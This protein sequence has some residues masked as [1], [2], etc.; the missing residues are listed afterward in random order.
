[1]GKRDSRGQAAGKN[2]QKILSCVVAVFFSVLLIRLFSLQSIRY[3]E[4][5]RSAENNQLQAERVVAPRGYFE[6]RAGKIIADNVLRFEFVLPWKKEKE[7]RAAAATLANYL[8]IDSGQVMERFAGWQKKN[9]TTP[10]PIVLDADKLMISFVRENSDLFPNLRVKTRARRRYRQSEV[11]AHVLGYVGEVRD[12]DLLREGA[13]RYFPG[14]MTGKTGLELYCESDLRGI[15]GQRV[16]EVNASGN[17]LGEVT[18]LSVPPHLGKTIT[19]TLDSGL[20]AYLQK[21]MQGKGAG[22]A[23]VMDVNDGAILAAVSVPGYDPNEFTTGISQEK[24]DALFN[25]ET[26]PLF[27]RVHQARY[28]PASTLKIVAT[29]AILVNEIVDPNEILVYCTGSHAFGN[30]VYHCWQAGG[31]GA[32]NLYTAFVQSCDIYFYRVGEMM[33]VDV[34]AQAAEA[35]GL[36]GKTGIELPGEVPGLVPDRKYYD[37]RF[38]K[39]RWT[40]GYVLNNIIGQGEFLTNPLHMVR[41]CAAVA[42]GGYL[43]KPH[44]IRNVGD[45]PSISYARHKVPF[46]AGSTL[47][48]LRRAMQGVVKDSGGTAYWTRIAGLSS[49]G[50]TGTAQNPH[51]EHHAWYTAYAPA[52]EPEIAIVVL[53]ENSGHGGE[54]AAPIVRDFFLEY[55]RDR[56]A[57]KS[58][59]VREGQKPDATGRIEPAAN[60]VTGVA[61]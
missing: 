26:K 50:K 30:R 1:M 18:E 59:A 47:D 54:I 13:E 60:T 34:L 41:V 25:E 44:I 52:D 16:L 31:H 48:F 11:T 58:A 14:D 38:G 39:G 12:A 36:A 19:L 37:E 21:L 5:S 7:V 49:A 55:F 40:Q 22:A 10:F 17:V 24:L 20:Q 35:F 42:N 8:P 6:D 4:Y 57:G 27:S 45:D 46:L 53:V 33:D 61:R 15:D 32:M 23:V 2:R 28:P 9:G 3:D 29:Y 56:V 43:V 51:G